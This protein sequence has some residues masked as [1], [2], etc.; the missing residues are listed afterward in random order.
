[1]SAQIARIA[2]QKQLSKDPYRKVHN[3]NKKP[4][5]FLVDDNIINLTTGKNALQKDYTVFTIPSGEKLFISLKNLKPDLILLDIDMPGMNGYETIAALKADPEFAEIPVI[6]L[7]AK[8]EADDELE[9]LTLGAVDYITKPFSQSILKKRVELHMMLRQQK[10]ELKNANGNL[11][12]MVDERISD[13]SIMQNAIIQ[14]AAEVIEFRDEETGQHVD[15]VQ[16]YLKLLINEMEKVEPYSYEIADW[17]IDAFL[18]STLLHDVGKIKIRDEILLKKSRL[19]EEEIENMKLHTQYGKTLIE[20]L[21]DKVPN[22]TFLDYAKELAHRHHERWDGTGYPDQLK[23]E[24]IPLQA[25]MMS[26]ADVYDALISVRPYK[27]AMPHDEAMR[28]IAEGSGTQFDPYLV[29]IFLK[30]SDKIRKVSE[31]TQSV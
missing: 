30:L 7:T 1:M 28:I 21:Q 25:R 4:V 10:E 26:I 19:T 11:M 13:I 2:E 16:K 6:F 15:R 5:V 27:P 22:E 24:D 23:E 8:N 17:D 9:G 29:E 3:V 14:W 18:K 12:E 20:S 31:G